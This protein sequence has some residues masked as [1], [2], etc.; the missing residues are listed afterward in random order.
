MKP[1]LRI[2]KQKYGWSA[3]ITFASGVKKYSVGLGSD[4]ALGVAAAF[5]FD[6]KRGI[7]YLKTH[8]E[9]K[10]WRKA[11]REK[12]KKKEKLCF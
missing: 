5:L 12:A 1:S 7:P 6:A 11:M 4:E 2:A 3:C 8:E 10:A 9:E